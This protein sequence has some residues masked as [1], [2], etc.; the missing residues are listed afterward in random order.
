MIL[1]VLFEIFFCWRFCW[2]VCRLL[3]LIFFEEGVRYYCEVVLVDDLI[4]EDEEDS[5]LIDEG[6]W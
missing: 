1:I 2:R 4:V 5:L 6:E 3:G